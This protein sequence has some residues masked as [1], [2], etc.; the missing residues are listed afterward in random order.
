MTQI[1][2]HPEY[3][4]TTDGKIYSMI[5]N[6]GNSRTTPY[7]L[8]TI[9]GRDGYHWVG[10]K[11]SN[12]KMCKVHRLVA[13]TF[14]DNPNNLPVVNHIDGNKLNNHVSNL[15]WC[16]HQDNTKHAH[17]NG[18]VSVKHGEAHPNSKLQD[19]DTIQLISL[20]LQGYTNDE[21]AEMFNL[22]SRYISLIRHKR[23]QQAIWDKHFPAATTQQSAKILKSINLDEA[24]ALVKAVFTTNASNSELAKK[25]AVD[26]SIVSRI[27]SNDKR[28]QSYFKPFILKY[29]QPLTTIEN[30]PLGGS[31]QSRLKR[32]ETRGT[33]P[34]NAEGYDI[35]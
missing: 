31:E 19:S 34:D 13:Q 32:V 1:P 5:N 17:A 2:N 10:L 9:I 3:Y 15:E 16:T 27:R 23:R 4:V 20:I 26:P 18:L 30:T 28:V 22:H 24:E 33:L 8:T 35:V 29:K 6:A 21:L 12:K 11:G 25:F 14:I 7:Q